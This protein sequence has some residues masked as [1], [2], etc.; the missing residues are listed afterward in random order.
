MNKLLT[1][2]LALAA[3]LSSN[4][5]HAEDDPFYAGAAIGAKGKLTFSRDG[6]SK[7]ESN[8]PL[9]YKV[10]GGYQL[11]DNF[12]LE[13]GYTNLGNFNYGSGP[14]LDLSVAYLAAKGSIPLGESFSVYGKLGV[15]RHGQKVSGIGAVDGSYH[16]V[17]AMFGV[18]TAYKLTENVSLTAE[19]VN[20]GTV[21]NR[22]G[23]IKARKFELGVNYSF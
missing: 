16:K 22:V 14:E 5:A 10:F 17:K 6:V 8:R 2:L 12:A 7:E 3:I 19:V 1:S 9:S 23:V 4:L 11:N 15:A 13:A 20:Y 18:G 21:K